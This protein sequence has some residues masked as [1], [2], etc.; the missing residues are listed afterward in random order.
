MTNR[1]IAVLALIRARV[2]WAD[3]ALFV[4][5]E[6]W[7]AVSNISGLDRLGS[8]DG[9]KV[10]AS[11]ILKQLPSKAPETHPAFLQAARIV[12]CEGARKL[13]RRR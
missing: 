2:R 3:N 13:A 12:G 4:L 5:D 11:A 1:G 9:D 10:H 8:V 6:S 7:G